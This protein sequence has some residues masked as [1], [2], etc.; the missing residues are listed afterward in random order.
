M[1]HDA[2][3]IDGS[4]AQRLNRAG[5][6]R[7]GRLAGDY[8]ASGGRLDDYLELHLEHGRFKGQSAPRLTQRSETVSIR[9]CLGGRGLAILRFTPSKSLPPDAGQWLVDLVELLVGHAAISW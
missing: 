8:I 1:M 4:C 3:E 2:Y 6:W 9:R 7:A 5:R